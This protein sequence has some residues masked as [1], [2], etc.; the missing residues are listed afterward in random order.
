MLSLPIDSIARRSSNNKQVVDCESLTQKK[1]KVVNEL[2]KLRGIFVMI[3][4]YF[5]YFFNWGAV[6][7]LRCG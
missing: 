1:N 4:L 3:H 6:P 5:L 7:G 2:S